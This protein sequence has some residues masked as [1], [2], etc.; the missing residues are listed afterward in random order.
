MA[1]F[2]ADLLSPEGTFSQKNKTDEIPVELK[3][4]QKKLKLLAKGLGV[5]IVMIR[6]KKKKKEQMQKV[7]HK[8]RAKCCK[9]KKWLS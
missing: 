3:Y 4:F 6:R 7:I 1:V 5:K 8:S 2:G 9:K